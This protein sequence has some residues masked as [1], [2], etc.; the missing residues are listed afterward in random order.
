M[1]KQSNQTEDQSSPR[2]QKPAAS[3]AKDKS[4]DRS[5]EPK[6]RQPDERSPPPAG[7]HARSD[8]TNNDATPGSGALPSDKRDGE[9]DG[10]T[11]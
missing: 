4:P 1:T 2:E 8:L 10:A 6:D 5:A 11:G 9:A 7:P 3:P